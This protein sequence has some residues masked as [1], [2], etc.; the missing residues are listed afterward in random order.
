MIMLYVSMPFLAAAAVLFL[1]GEYFAKGWDGLSFAVYGALILGAWAVLMLGWCAW[2]LLRDGLVPS[3][4]LPGA[5][6][7]AALAGG[8]LWGGSKLLE[9]HRCDRSAQFFADYAQAAP[10]DRP[11]LIEKNRRFVADPG[12]CGF[13]AAQYW[14]G[15]DN[16]GN[17]VAPHGDTERLA[18]LR[19]LLAAGLP[20]ADRLVYA[21]AR[22]GDADAVRLLAGHR[23]AAGLAPWPL[24]PAVAALQ[25]Y[26][27]GEADS[28][29]RARHLETLRLFVEG[30]ADLC[31]PTETRQT[32]GET[33]T[34]AGVPWRDWRAP[35]GDSCQPTAPGP[36]DA[37]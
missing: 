22:A 27:Y 8:G 3:S 19:D 29:M 14:L 21:A 4:L 33:M 20:P 11:G 28:P 6:L 15:L 7:V 18:A 12:W 36:P 23:P 10:A 5:V 2:I 9:Q 1:I 34:R 17:P 25:G 35:S 37:G 24:R 13:D 26:E 16:D 30:G 31:A 32:L